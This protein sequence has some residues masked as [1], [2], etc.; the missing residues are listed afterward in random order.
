MKH[1]DDLVIDFE[2]DHDFFVDGA[3]VLPNTLRSGDVITINGGKSFY[4]VTGKRWERRKLVIECE[5]IID[6]AFFRVQW[7]GSGEVYAV[8]AISENTPR[9]NSGPKEYLV[10]HRGRKQWVLANDCVMA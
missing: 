3:Q 8:E 2:Q 6:K 4:K 5:K 7:E 9:E 10:T 1:N